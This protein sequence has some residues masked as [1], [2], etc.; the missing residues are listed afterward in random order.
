MSRLH[1]MLLVQLP[2]PFVG[3]LAT[4]MF[5]LFL[6]FLIRYLPDLVG[7]GLPVGVITEL[8]AYNLAYMV[9]LAV[10][11]S[12]FIATLM[13]FGRL[14]ETNSYAVIKGAGISFPRLVWPVLVAGGLLAAGMTYFNNEVLPE[15]NFRAKNLWQDIRRKKPTFALQE[16]VFYEGLND[17]SILVHRLPPDSNA[18]VDV[19][20]YDYS[21]GTAQQAV[22]KAQRG[23]IASDERSAL[24]EL[25]LE[26]GEVHR[27]VPASGDGAERYERL[28]FD[29]YRIRLD[30]SGFSFD[31]SNPDDGYRSDRTMR[32]ADM[33]RVVDSLEAYAAAQQALLLQDLRL[34]GRP[35]TLPTDGALPEAT[36]GAMPPLLRPPGAEALAEPPPAATE[37]TLQPIDHPL[38]RALPVA[39]QH[40]VLEVASQEA[41]SV[42]ARFDDANRFIQ[43]Q[44]QRANQYRVEIY[45]KYSIAFACLIFVLVGA[46]LGLSL[47]RGGLGVAALLAVGIFLFY[48]VTL[49]NGEKFADRGKL[50][51]WVGM[52]SAN[53]LIGLFG[54][55]LSA[56][57]TFDLRATPPLWKRLRR[58]LQRSR[59]A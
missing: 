20:L 44:R 30:L 50:E 40:R 29:R 16:G 43:G 5:V 6:Q 15:A 18:L 17:F 3:W 52:W 37:A 36:P 33:V 7:K 21:D 11:M 28:A 26:Q 39:Q 31:R 9:V 2:G 24:V 38:V 49:V 13:V 57:V 59:P 56:Y 4:L 58:R 32:T 8:V 53:V 46:P 48:W 54:L 55:W 35:D 42:R 23:Y 45:K 1:R 51:P 41:H 14:A 34:R 47:R 25:V 10:P 19:T 27:A 12:A 22:V